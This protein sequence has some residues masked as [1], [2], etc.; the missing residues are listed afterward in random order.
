MGEGQGESLLGEA[1]T[2]QHHRTR[3][4]LQKL[5]RDAGVLQLCSIT[6]CLLTDTLRNSADLI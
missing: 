3:D 6:H 2:L 5:S 1:L 4:A